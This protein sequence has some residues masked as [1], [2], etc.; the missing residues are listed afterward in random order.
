MFCPACGGESTEGLKY[1]KRCGSSLTVRDAPEER[2]IPAFIV[3]FMLFVMGAI[4]M[5]GIMGPLAALRDF[6]SVG[7][8]PKE[9]LVS[10]FLCLLLT[11]GVEGTL[12]WLMTR[13]VAAYGPPRSKKKAK[14]Q[15]QI[16]VRVP[17]AEI[18]APPESIGSVTEGTTRTFAHMAPPKTSH[19]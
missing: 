6:A 8:R 17:R 3:V 12:A 19:E 13:L 10:V 15:A 18:A 9:T 2:G 14:A 16:E 7:F 1:C 4:G 5:A 11:L